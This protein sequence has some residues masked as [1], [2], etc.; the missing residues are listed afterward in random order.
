M[1]APVDRLTKQSISWL[2]SHRCK[3]RHPYLAHFTCFLNDFPDTKLPKRVGVFS[4]SHCGHKAGLTPLA[5]QSHPSDEATDRAKREAETRRQLWYLFKEK[6]D[7][8]KP[9][10]VVIWNGDCIDGKGSKSGGNEQITTNRLE[11]AEMAGLCVQECESPLN[12]ITMG[13]PYHT[14]DSEDFER[15]MD[16]HIK[17]QTI[18][19]DHAF[20]DVNGCVLDCKHKIGGSTIPHGRLTAALKEKVWADLWRDAGVNPNSNIIIRS[21]VHYFGH[22]KTST[23]DAIVTPALQG[24]GSLYGKRQCSGIVDWGFCWIDIEGPN[25][26]E[27]HEYLPHKANERQKVDVIQV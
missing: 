14:G 23:C 13:T 18:F 4:D 10:D 5:F 12:V 1:K 7:D 3:H 6:V 27:I 22:A 8:L 21:H 16:K 26:Y 24:L 20:V 2:S 9:F 17:G 25:N 11:Q 19:K 15:T